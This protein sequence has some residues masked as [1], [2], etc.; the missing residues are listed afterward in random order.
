MTSPPRAWMAAMSLP[1][2]PWLIGSVESPFQSATQGLPTGVCRNARD[3]NLAPDACDWPARPP[4]LMSQASKYGAKI[5]FGNGR[6]PA[7]ALAGAATA[8]DDSMSTELTS[9][10][11]DPAAA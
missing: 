2:M 10:A 7:A 1:K 8:S 3:R 9:S 6:P 4:A 11:D 5:R